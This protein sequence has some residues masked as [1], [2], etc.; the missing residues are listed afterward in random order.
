MRVYTSG[1]G[2]GSNTSDKHQRASITPWH[3]A[4]DHHCAVVLAP[5]LP[6]S[7]VEKAIGHCLFVPAFV[8]QRRR[9]VDSILRAPQ[10]PEP[11]T[12]HQ[13][14]LVAVPH[15]ERKDV[16]YRTG[17]HLLEHGVPKGP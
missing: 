3:E 8:Q 12:G 17:P 5:S 6:H 11:I 4:D 14:K 16:R 10:V 7:D 15:L 2:F 1:F 9:R 13:H